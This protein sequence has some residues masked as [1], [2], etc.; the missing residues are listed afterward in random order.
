MML[1]I[2]LL[3]PAPLF[4]QVLDSSWTAISAS[5]PRD[6]PIYCLETLGLE[7]KMRDTTSTRSLGFNHK[8][9]GSSYFA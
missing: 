8:W 5:K 7:D 4:N 9:A 6:P 3:L 1:A 2:G